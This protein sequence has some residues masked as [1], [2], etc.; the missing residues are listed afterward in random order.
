MKTCTK[1][2][3]TKTIVE[4]R[5]D[6]TRKD[7]KFPWCAE[8]HREDARRR[9]EEKKKA[10]NCRYKF[11]LEYR[12]NKACNFDPEKQK[13]YRWNNKEKYYARTKLGNALRDGKIEK[14]INCSRCH[15]FSDIIEG[16]HPDYTKPLEVIWLCP[17]CHGEQVI[18]DKEL[19]R[20]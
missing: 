5:N 14:P 19:R 11:D 9:W 10:N 8:C 20:Y 16:H 12:R 13:E 6:R 7:G 17:Y 18:E 2:G 4:F 15:R 3:Q 1:C